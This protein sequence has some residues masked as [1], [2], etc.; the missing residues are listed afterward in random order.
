MSL[1]SHN[2][3]KLQLPRHIRA[4]VDC[5]DKRLQICD[6]RI[7]P[8]LKTHSTS[9]DVAEINNE[10]SNKAFIRRLYIFTHQELS[11]IEAMRERCRYILFRSCH[12]SSTLSTCSGSVLRYRV[13]SSWSS[14]AFGALRAGK[15][16]KM[17]VSAR[18]INKQYVWSVIMYWRTFAL[19]IVEACCCWSLS[20]R[21]QTTPNM[22]PQT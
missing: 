8:W 21:R 6:R 16:S 13:S 3:I 12:Q 2:P 18:E 14:L 22:I 4:C 15:L 17:F 11:I 10:V 5:T 9:V 20:C 1:S 7:L 19:T